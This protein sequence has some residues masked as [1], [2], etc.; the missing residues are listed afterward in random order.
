MA[1][2][3]GIISLLAILALVLGGVAYLFTLT[4]KDTFSPTKFQNEITSVEQVSESDE[5]DEIEKD[6]DQTDIES[7]DTELSTIEAEFNF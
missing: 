1:G 7:I 6:L 2:R 4:A 5:I 3:R